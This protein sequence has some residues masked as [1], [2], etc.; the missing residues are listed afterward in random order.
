MTDFNSDK[1]IKAWLKQFRKHP[2]YDDG[3]IREMELH[4]RDHMEELVAEGVSEKIAFEQAV[5]EFGSIEPVAKEELWN[6]KPKTSLRS[7]L[8]WV[9]LKNYF[10]TSTR[11]LFKN[12]LTSFINV[13]GLAVA[14]GIC[15]LVYVFLA[16]DNSIDQFHTKKE[17]VYLAT[18]YINRDGDLE[19]NGRTPRPL[20]ALMAQDMPQVKQVCRVD[21]GP[22]IIK[23]RDVVFNEQ[24]RYVDPN[25]LDFF[26][27]PMAKG[28]KKGLEDLNSIV[29]SHAMG[30]KYFG[31][32]NPIGE[33]VTVIFG[34]NNKKEFTVVGVAAPFPKAHAIAF[35]F[36]VHYENLKTALPEFSDDDWGA[37]VSATLIQV[38][39]INQIPQIKQS[40]EGY[41]MAQNKAQP[42]W[43]IHSFEFEKLADLHKVSGRIKNDISY[44]DN[45]EGRIGLPV[46]ALLMLALACLNYINIAI[47]TA[48]KRLKEIGV[49][50]VIGANKRQ[51]IVQFLLENMVTTSFAMLLGV[52][53]GIFLFL[54][55]FI[56]FTGWDLELNTMS[57]DFWLFITSILLATGLL[58]G[59]YPAFYISKF[60]TV[61]IF[62][63]AQKFGKNNLVTK[64]FLGVQ[65]VLACTTI[66]VGI[67]VAQNNAYQSQKQWGYQ[68]DQ[69]LYSAL[70][71]TK[72][73]ENL[74]IALEK[75]PSIQTVV[76][77]KEHVGLTLDALVLSHNSI[78]YEVSSMSVGPNYIE[79]LNFELVAGRSFIDKKES[80]KQALVLNEKAVE[81][82]QLK[83]P[84]GALLTIQNVKYEVIGVVKDFHF[85]NFFNTIEPMVMQ[86]TEE[87]KFDYIVLRTEK[88]S[89]QKALSLLK[90][91]W[92]KQNPEL[93]FYGGHQTETWGVFFE[94]IQKAKDFNAI[95]AVVAVFLA[96]MGLYGLVSLNVSGRTKE[97]SIRKTLGAGLQHLSSN[98]LKEYVWLT[99]IALLVGGPMSYIVSK[100]YLDMLFAY[101]M[102]LDYSGILMALVVLVVVLLLV[103]A[104]QVKKVFQS[105]PVKGLQAE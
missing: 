104:T 101:P 46:I 62:R 9:M 13:F 29:L 82:L 36:L 95:I 28:N 14:I 27:F 6:V 43:S 74:K 58:S 30:I 68:P 39:D 92:L 37:F 86:L 33:L 38:D 32:N 56:G 57:S 93:P 105:N 41:R 15:L 25:F 90:K 67:V 40:M 53:M 51:V 42:D 85:H 99:T 60:D 16:W 102:P 100:A 19:Q 2:F 35:D 34:E 47:V 52:G 87:T 23:F 11:S 75:H 97:F 54:P 45:L 63:G 81:N 20:G 7:I 91:E 49:R 73:F 26:T 98:I 17:E 83:N 64:A 61:S 48:S 76:G 59:I 79:T 78:Q 94:M 66:A 12:P 22:V 69:L 84:I 1:A 55:W 96:G 89:E 71:K 103:V 80:D 5:E 65:L 4:L 10:K 3:S 18:T 77:A 44:D 70:Q 88:G 72:S 24:L 31:E 50:K 8:H 21:D